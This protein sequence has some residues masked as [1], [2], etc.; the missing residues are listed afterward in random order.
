[1]DYKQ[2]S[3]YLHQ[4]ITNMSKITKTN[5][6]KIISSE[7]NKICQLLDVDYCSIYKYDFYINSFN[8]L[9]HST[10]TK[11]RETSFLK[12]GKITDLTNDF[13]NHHLENENYLIDYSSNSIELV[14]N[15][16]ITFTFTM[17]IFV[18]DS[19]FGFFKL[20]WSSE[21]LD[22]LPYNLIIMMIEGLKGLFLKGYWV[23]KL[24][25]NQNENANLI[26]ENRKV[27]EKIIYELRTPLN[28]ITNSLSIL[29]NSDL[30]K[31][32]AEK[33]NI[34]DYCSKLLTTEI[35]SIISLRKD[36]YVLTNDS[37]TVD[38]KSELKKIINIHKYH[39]KSY[40]TEVELDF[41]YK[42]PTNTFADIKKIRQIISVL[43]ESAIKNV[44]EGKI[45]LNVFT[46]QIRIP[47]VNV[48]FQIEYKGD[49]FLTNEDF[50]HY[51]DIINSEKTEKIDL[52]YKEIKELIE[53]LGGIFVI[54]NNKDENLYEFYLKL[55]IA[56]HADNMN[57]K[58]ENNKTD[59]SVSST[60]TDFGSYQ[61]LV[62]D[63]NRINR[64]VLRRLLKRQGVIAQEATSGFE[65]IELSEKNLFD[66]IF[67]DI[68]MPGLDGY[69]TTSKI[70]EL[71]NSNKDIP[72][73]AV[74]ANVEDETKKKVFESGMNGYIPKP[75]SEEIIADIL[76][77]YDSEKHEFKLDYDTSNKAF[78]EKKFA[79][80]Y[81]DVDFQIDILD[82]FIMEYD[83]DFQ[84]IKEAY[85]S[86]DVQRVNKVLHYMKGSFGS[87]GAEK[88]NILTENIIKNCKSEK[89]NLIK[90]SIEVFIK[91]FDEL[92]QEIKVYLR[93]IKTKL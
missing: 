18:E 71:S 9:N 77:K 78:D 10:R 75:L 23:N 37:A 30:Y 36:K 82:A 20:D 80:T 47:Y 16:D 49:S 40:G 51:Y 68:L 3:E 42:I 43:L 60:S 19:C 63:D 86:K 28:E 50:L 45:K 5:F 24:E 31:S 79:S 13:L 57:T 26:Q 91:H 72:I 61:V 90:D 38:L 73:F 85:E 64:R 8:C 53:V 6:D 1:M 69:E 46:E 2:T 66:M 15:D 7:L 93:I 32:H 84:A 83:N 17:P 35:N 81:E 48:V 29:K 58:I 67:M 52:K 54:V 87:L 89:F 34:M 70:R 92:H 65:A 44:S 59:F 88:I 56:T 12:Q 4:V 22:D 62:V 11:K 39:A 41:S 74:T 33:I 55:R 25:D 76:K 14:F 27:I 21:D